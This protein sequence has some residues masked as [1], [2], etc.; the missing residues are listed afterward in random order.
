MRLS[1]PI[2]HILVDENIVR[3]NGLFS[4]LFVF[5]GY[6]QPW[7]LLLL[8]LDYFIRAFTRKHSPITDLSR[9]ITKHLK[10]SPKP[11]DGAPKKFAA[12]IGAVMSTLLLATL[13]FE[14]YLPAF[15]IFTV[16]SLAISLE[17]FFNYCVG[18]QIYSI[19]QNLHITKK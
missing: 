17:T 1:C 16:F 10:L 2:S 13:F 7:I 19:L 3:L 11:I 18:C 4:L 6:F 12:K 14:L 9:W 15:I 5:L 8:A